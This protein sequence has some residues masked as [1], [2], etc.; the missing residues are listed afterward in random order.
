MT[1]TRQRIE[2]R[3]LLDGHMLC[4]IPAYPD[5]GEHGQYDDGARTDGHDV[6]RWLQWSRSVVRYQFRSVD[7]YEI[8]KKLFLSFKLKKTIMVNNFTGAHGRHL[9]E[10]LHDSVV[11]ITATSTSFACTYGNYH[12]QK[13]IVFCDFDEI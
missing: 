9:I 7:F 3:R 6:G 13:F 10:G 4:T 5:G 11:H 1:Y 8:S 2:V 12:E